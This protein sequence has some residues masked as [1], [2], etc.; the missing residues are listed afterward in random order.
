MAEI[1]GDEVVQAFPHL[2][3][4][5]VG[6][7]GAG[8][9]TRRQAGDGGQAALGEHEDLLHGVLVGAAGQAVTAALAAQTLQ[10]AVLHQHLEDVLQILFRDL[11]PCGDF[12]EGNVFFRLM[13]GKVDHH[14]QRIAPFGGNDH[15]R[16][17]PLM[18]I[19]C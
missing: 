2:I 18:S 7:A 6:Q 16:V 17:L 19:E 10:K 8:G 1:V 15:I 5:A 11:L 4:A 14:A 13:F 12:L 3:G 9:C